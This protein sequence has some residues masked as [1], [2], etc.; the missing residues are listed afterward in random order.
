MPCQHAREVVCCHG[1]DAQAGVGGMGGRRVCDLVARRG[2]GGNEWGKGGGL[3]ADIGESCRQ[4][5]VS[6]VILFR[7]EFRVGL[8]TVPFD[9]RL[10]SKPE[11]L[12]LA[13][14]TVNL[15][16]TKT[17]ATESYTPG[18][19]FCTLTYLTHF[20]LPTLPTTALSTKL[21]PWLELELLVQRS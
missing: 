1:M 19:L 2:N 8:S 10:R 21:A 13:T 5:C 4:G 11:S 6:S 15:S 3:A 14:H 7:V 18:Q 17:N 20:P 16:T 9:V 12:L